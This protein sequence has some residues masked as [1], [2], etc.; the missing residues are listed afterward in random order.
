MGY[1]HELDDRDQ[2]EGW[3]AMTYADGRISGGTSC[4]AGHYLDGYTYLPSDPNDPRTWG[5]IDPIYLRPNSEITGWL[6]R[7]A[8]GWLGIETPVIEPNDQWREP[9]EDQEHLIMDQWRLH[10]RDAFPGAY[11]MNQLSAPAVTL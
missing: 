11:P 10:L 7:C 6:P 3:I 4:A 5:Q 8:C 9:A 1:T 2:H